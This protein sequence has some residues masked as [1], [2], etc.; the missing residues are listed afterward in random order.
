[1]SADPTMMTDE[2]AGGEADSRHGRH[3][4]APQQIPARGWW[5]IV[6]RAYRETGRDNIAIV[7]GGVTYY[8]LFALFPALALLVSLYGLI[9]NPAEVHRQVQALSAA[10][11]G[12]A[13][14]V[15][16]GELDQIAKSSGGALSLG[17][18]VGF[19]VSFYSASRGI[20]GLIT[21]LN[22]AYEQKET[23]GFF[24]LNLLAAVLTLLLIVVA[25]VALALV[26]GVPAV[27]TSLGLGSIVKWL[28]LI[29]E[30]PLLLAIVLGVLAVLY[31]YAPDRREPQW[32]WITPGAT[33]AT[34]LWLIGSI[35]FTIYVANFGSYNKTY[36]SL[37]AVI[38]M[39]TWMY[40]SSYVVLFGA[41]V[42]AESERQTRRDTTTGAEKPMGSRGAH[43]ADTLGESYGSSH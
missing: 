10:I 41:E 17:V 30:W 25:I 14:Q 22:I 3:A 18:V 35:L 2:K 40:L 28:A 43:A 38:G 12:G 33:V 20:S 26:A 15:I 32:R 11:P 39:L 4:E 27:V 13:Q 23:R 29:L 9:S 5:D 16:G 1:M 19:L 21:A 24:R 37:G 36:G 6:W 42:N 8:A 7:A 31:R 34:V